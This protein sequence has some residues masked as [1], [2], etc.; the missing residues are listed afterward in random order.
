MPGARPPE[1]HRFSSVERSIDRT[2]PSAMD[3][4]AWPTTQPKR[5]TAKLCEKTNPTR[6]SAVLLKRIVSTTDKIGQKATMTI[7]TQQT[8]QSRIIT[9]GGGKGG[10]GKSIVALNLAAAF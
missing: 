4:A 2:S 7:A 10:G 5:A 1:T 6:C 9:V 8:A 3:G